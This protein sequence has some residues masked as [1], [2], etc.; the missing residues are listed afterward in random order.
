MKRSILTLLLFSLLLISHVQAQI[1]SG[2]Y[3][4]GGGV[5]FNYSQS[6]YGGKENYLAKDNNVSF[7]LS[8]S[9][10][11]FIMDNLSLAISLSYGNYHSEG[12][13]KDGYNL[14]SA[15]KNYSIGP[16]LR[17]YLQYT[18]NAYV[19]LLLGYNYNLGYSN[20]ESTLNSSHDDSDRS[21]HNFTLGVGNSFFIK[22]YLAVEPKIILQY[23]N[24]NATSQGAVEE[25]NYS[26][27]RKEITKSVMFSIGLAY[28]IQ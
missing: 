16:S 23:E 10:G 6:T 2:T 17:Y 25:Y 21:K 26:S 8:S 1:E 9:F 20:Y 11:Y 7:Y 13:Y 24:Y 19:F 14:T 28:Y 4:L 12:N 27:S 5:S 22:E 18:D 3:T 15:F